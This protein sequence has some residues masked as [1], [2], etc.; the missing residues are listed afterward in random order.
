MRDI[1]DCH[2]HL[3]ADDERWRATGPAVAQADLPAYRQVQ[4]ALDS[5][6]AVIVQPLLYGQDNSLML[7]RLRDLGRGRARGVAIAPAGIADRDLDALHEAGV[8]GVRFFVGSAL[9]QARAAGDE[10]ALSEMRALDPRLAERGMHLQVNTNG[11]FLQTRA[12][13]FRG[14]ASALVFDHLG[15]VL[16]EADGTHTG[17]PG[18]LDLMGDGNVWVKASGLYLDSAAP[19]P[20]EDMR[21][22]L[23]RLAQAFPL[24]LVWGTNWPHPTVHAGQRA[25]DDPAILHAVRGWLPDAALQQRVL[26]ENAA[27]LYGFGASEA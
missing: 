26:V 7:R 3:Y 23:Q 15:H 11:K 5:E 4:R 6:R 2:L 12:A 27:A 18:L 21:P 13:A 19:E 1:C 25:P 8:R 10:H 22:A 14:F 17:L 20:H 9:A 24:R 16:P